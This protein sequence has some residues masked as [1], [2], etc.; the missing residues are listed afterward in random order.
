MKRHSFQQLQKRQKQVVHYFKVICTS[1]ENKHC[2]KAEAFPVKKQLE[3]EINELEIGLDHANKATSEGLKS[4]PCA[5][6]Y[7]MVEA[8]Q[9]YL[10]CYAPP[11][12]AQKN[13]CI[14][15]FDKL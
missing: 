10:S 3:E 11:M 14:N 15:N 4:T 13:K 7:G 1:I 6:K 9:H 8:H 2:A 5:A 12:L